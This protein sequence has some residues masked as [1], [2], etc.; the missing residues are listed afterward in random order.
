[1]WTYRIG[2]GEIGRGEG[3]KEEGDSDNLLCFVHVNFFAYSLAF[4][5]AIEV[6][7]H[8]ELVTLTL[9]ARFLGGYLFPYFNLLPKVV[10]FSLACFRLESFF[11]SD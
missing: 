9:L 5:I 4:G 3:R 11:P 10:S 6:A 1:M 8:V 2:L 7:W